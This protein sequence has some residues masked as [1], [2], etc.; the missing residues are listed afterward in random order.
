MNSDWMVRVM[1]DKKTWHPSEP[2]GYWRTDIVTIDC[3]KL[4]DNA[5]AAMNSF[6][7]KHGDD[8]E[9]V[10]VSIDAK[11]ALY[12]LT[13]N[14]NYL[15]AWMHLLKATPELSMLEVKCY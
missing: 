12:Y 7:E 6:H 15:P 5:V 1:S 8:P 10:F 4:L 9:H 2:C 11:N 13:T 3:K 14:L